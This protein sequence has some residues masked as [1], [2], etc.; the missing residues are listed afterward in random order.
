MAGRLAA[1]L[2]WRQPGRPPRAMLLGMLL[3]VEVLLPLG[4]T[5]Q[6]LPLVAAAA[7][8]TP[9]SDPPAEA[10]PTGAA[11]AATAAA[12]EEEERGS[13]ADVAAAMLARAAAAVARGADGWAHLQ[14]AVHTGELLRGAPTPSPRPLLVCSW[15]CRKNAMHFL[16][17]SPGCPADEVHA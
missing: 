9:G 6:G 8:S 17:C 3:L 16:A 4:L 15:G 2:A 1:A 7:G 5:P 14:A 11:A 12:A 10:D 13:P